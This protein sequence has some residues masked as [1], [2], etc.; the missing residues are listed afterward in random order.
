MN[1]NMS[2]GIDTNTLIA[3]VKA[4]LTTPKTEWPAI[5]ARPENAAD[6]YKSYVLILAAIPA[7]AGFIKSCV[8][9]INIPLAGTV[10]LSFGAGLS[11]MVMSYVLSVVGV[12]IIALIIDALAPTFG[13]EK[14]Q[15]QAL[16]VAAYSYTAAW[17]AGVAQIL[18]F[19]GWIV[20]LA[21]GLYSLYLLYLGLPVVMKAPQDRALGY[22]GLVIAAAVVLYLLIGL[23][24]SGVAGVNRIA[25]G[26]G[27]T[28]GDIT[29]DK[30]SYLGKVEGA[31]KKLEEAQKSGDTAAQQEA[32]GE[33]MST[34][35]G[36]AADVEA[37]AP[38]RLRAF[39]PEKLSGLD[40]TSLS[41]ERNAA[42]GVQVSNAEA[43]YS[44]GDEKTIRLE[45]T[46]MGG[47]K[48]MMAFAAWA[49]VEQERETETG[50][51]KTYKKG[52]RILHEEWDNGSK[53]G[54]YTVVV[55]ERFSV[56]V[57]GHARDI[58][59]LKDAAHSID[60]SGLEKLKAEGVKKG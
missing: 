27:S 43:R 4:I 51:E 53:E 45:I 12:F 57:S 16:K 58:E 33:M 23:A 54:E 55:G 39:V 15:T 17:V 3:R 49:Q 34:A 42:L 47:T 7:V 37:L 1:T 38:E 20:A 2:A 56:K 30:D 6:I 28:S 50:Y 13:G 25:G 36:G 9:G 19:I 26:P 24:V 46:D 41:V 44:D 21:G 29:F 52:G 14:N 18:P 32:L 48:G 10:R 8:I 11:G 22:T 59:E 31:S 35:L 60:L 40:R 5:A